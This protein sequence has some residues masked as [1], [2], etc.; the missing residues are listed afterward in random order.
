MDTA[1]QP[2]V[3]IPAKVWYRTTFSGMASYLD[4]AAIISTGTALVLYKEPLG[5]SDSNIGA[6]S[7]IL[8]FLMAIGALVG[9]RLGDVFG[10]RRVFMVTMALYTVGA[11]V[12][13]TASSA[14]RSTSTR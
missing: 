1:A 5:L 2:A 11:A 9:G 13:M 3:R 12:M 7:A 10:R 14:T 8:T 6:L 4:A